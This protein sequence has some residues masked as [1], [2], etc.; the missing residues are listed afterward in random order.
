LQVIKEL[1]PNLYLDLFQ[2]HSEEVDILIGADICSLHS[3]QVVA[4]AGSNLKVLEGP[5]GL[6]LHGT[7]SRLRLS[8]EQKSHFT[9]T[10]MC[11]Q[12]VEKSSETFELQHLE[13]SKPHTFL[14]GVRETVKWD[15]LIQ[16]E[17]LGTEQTVKGSAGESGKFPGVRPIF[18]FR[19][20]E[21]QTIFYNLQCNLANKHWMTK[22]LG[23]RNP[24]ELR[25]NG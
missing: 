20:Q 18:S 13:F 1:F 6:C 2:R 5:F 24:Q 22:N 4:T 23:V 8:G 10:S 14:T 25:S 9:Q 3:R 16:G 7:H 21:L 17:S 11:S 12:V 19:K 15:P